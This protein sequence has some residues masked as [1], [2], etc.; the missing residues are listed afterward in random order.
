MW[1]KLA[2][3]S[4]KSNCR[5]LAFFLALDFHLAATMSARQPFVPQQPVSNQSGS[6]PQNTNANPNAALQKPQLN[7]MD[8]GT[9]KPL[10]LSGL[11]KPKSS[12]KQQNEQP[13]RI[14]TPNLKSRGSFEGVQR[15]MKPAVFSKNQGSIRSRMSNNSAKSQAQKE[16]HSVNQN[17]QGSPFFAAPNSNPTSG[18]LTTSSNAAVAFKDPPSFH[19]NS[20]ENIAHIPTLAQG[21]FESARIMTTNTSQL[22][23]TLDNIPESVEEDSASTFGHGIDRQRTRS[24]LSDSVDLG[25]PPSSPPVL[26]PAGGAGATGLGFGVA[27]SSGNARLGLDIAVNT[28]LGAGSESIRTKRKRDRIEDEDQEDEDGKGVEYSRAAMK[29]WRGDSGQV[30]SSLHLF[31]HRL[32]FTFNFDVSFL[33]V[34]MSIC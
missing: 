15:P 17:L 10:N 24:S 1:E 33:S 25:E 7:L 11:I 19:L 28:H 2:K 3:V 12:H 32:R 23:S 22:R 27:V 34:Y 9:N 5:T 4:L 30:R 21:P 20:G 6:K 18:F 26:P 8:L 31:A 29:R 16:P 14:G 13:N